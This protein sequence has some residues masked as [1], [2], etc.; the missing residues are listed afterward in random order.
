MPLGLVVYTQT[1]DLPANLHNNGPSTLLFNSACS[2]YIQN[3]APKRDSSFTDPQYYFPSTIKGDKEGFPIYKLHTRRK[4]YC[5][6]FCRQSKDYCVVSDTLGAIVWTLQPEH[7]RFAQYDCRRATGRF[8]G[9]D[10]EVWYTLDIPIPS[11]P[12]KLGGLP[13]LILE[14][15]S[16]DGKVKFLFNG[17]QL[18]DKIVGTIKPPSGKDMNMTHPAF[19]AG[20]AEFHEYLVKKSKAKGVELTITQMEG[21]EL[22]MGN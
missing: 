1:I 20:E 18:S 22:N 21:I 8:R 13:G 2:A 19:I 10:Y 9:R 3:S 7:K 16:T 6:I 14:A 12:Y 11:G 15:V 4:M 5:K 17:L